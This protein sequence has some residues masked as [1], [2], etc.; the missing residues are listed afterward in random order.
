M[1][2]PLS[3]TSR[4]RAKLA[5]FSRASSSIRVVDEYAR[6]RDLAKKKRH[7]SDGDV[8]A[9]DVATRQNTLAPLAINRADHGKRISHV[10]ATSVG[11]SSSSSLAKF[12]ALLVSA[13][14]KPLSKQGIRSKSEAVAFDFE[15][16]T[17][18]EEEAAAEPGRADAA[19]VEEE[20]VFIGEK[21]PSAA[22]QALAGIHSIETL[23]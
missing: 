16:A 3:P 23:V 2:V 17:I 10:S 15:A 9:A 13:R 18:L 8:L 22:A 1:D 7:R 19:A 12:E 6:F 14:S 11:S 5:T 20:D 21:Q 4:V